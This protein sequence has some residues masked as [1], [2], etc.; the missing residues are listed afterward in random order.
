MIL[1]THG[2]TNE[3]HSFDTSINVSL[4]SS[5]HLILINEN[6]DSP[7]SNMLPT[8]QLTQKYVVPFII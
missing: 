7:Y 3:L 1:L 8:S 4:N 2:R 5:R 6:V